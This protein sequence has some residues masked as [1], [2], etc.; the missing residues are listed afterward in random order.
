M[1]FDR[2]ARLDG[3]ERFGLVLGALLSIVFLEFGSVYVNLG[4]NVGCSAAAF[5][6]VVFCVK[7]PLQR[8]STKVV[9][10]KQ[11]QLF[12]RTRRVDHTPQICEHSLK[13]KLSTFFW[14]PGY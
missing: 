1:L 14:L 6:Y 12:H 8:K 2:L 13:I 5:C 9:Y 4:V 10:S 3:V 11:L 7:E